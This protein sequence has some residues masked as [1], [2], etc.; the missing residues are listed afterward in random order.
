MCLYI[1][2]N[3]KNWCHTPLKTYCLVK[4]L[5]NNI[6]YRKAFTLQ[7]TYVP[8]SNS[9]LLLLLSRH[10][11]VASLLYLLDYQP[12]FRTTKKEETILQISSSSC[13]QHICFLNCTRFRLLFYNFHTHTFI[14]FH[15]LPMGCSLGFL[16]AQKIN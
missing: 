4:T 14:F 16:S 3:T 11:H 13:H 12:T 10:Q 2:V 7:S 6:G 9:I 15:I 1:Y 5:R 8:S